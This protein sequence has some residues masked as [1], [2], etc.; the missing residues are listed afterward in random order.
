MS[1]GL[2]ILLPAVIAL[3]LAIWLCCVSYTC[4]KQSGNITVS[5][6]LMLL[7][8]FPFGAFHLLGTSQCERGMN[9]DSVM[10]ENRQLKNEKLRAEIELL[11]KK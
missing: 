2:L 4:G 10:K 3:L 9:F 11:K 6:V 1:L 7:C 8:L 5:I